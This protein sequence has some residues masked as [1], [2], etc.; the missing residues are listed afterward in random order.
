VLVTLLLLQKSC[1]PKPKEV[2][3]EVITKVE[4]R[5]DTIQTVVEKYIP[6]WRDRIITQI[7]TVVTPIDTI[8]ILKDYYAKYVYSDTLQIDT[9]GYA[10]INDTITQNTILSRDIKTNLL[11]PTTTITNTVYI[12]ERELY[13]GVGLSG[14]T[15]QINYLGGELLYKTKQKQLYS[16]G[17]GVN[18]DFQPVLSARMYWNI[19]K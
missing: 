4:I 14:R 1:S 19:T 8:A 7:D 12:N 3:P 15:S 10:V 9:I 18:Q 2:E 6:R 17:V 13:F 11:I 5:Y 16:L